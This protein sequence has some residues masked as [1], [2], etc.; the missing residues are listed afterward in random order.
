LPDV[1][2]KYPKLKLVL[3][4]EGPL[5]ETLERLVATLHLENNVV[6]TGVV[7]HNALVDFYTSSDIFILSSTLESRAN[8]VLESLVCGTPVIT[9]NNPA[10]I[11]LAS[12]YPDDVTLLD[13]DTSFALASAIIKLLD[14]GRGV[15]EDT[16]ESI[17]EQLNKEIITQRFLDIYIDIVNKNK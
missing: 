12:Q 11:E 9:A 3:T 5:F 6:F 1:L 10:G 17:T 4:G 15:K 13:E 16:I 14:E 7:A 2:K 8:V